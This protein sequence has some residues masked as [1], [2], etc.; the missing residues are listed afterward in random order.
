MLKQLEQADL[1][2]HTG[3]KDR[4]QYG[5]WS[6]GPQLEVTGFFRVQ[7]EAGQWW[8]VDTDGRLF[9]S[10][11]VDCVTPGTSTPISDREHYFEALPESD[12]ILAKFYGRG[13]WA[14]H[15]YYKDHTPYR[16][17]DFGRANLF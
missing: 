17:Y 4:N 11:G 10:H 1:T 8:L 6:K 9:W 2:R 12:S 5:G 3:P 14:P 16:T 15:G 13:S 7:K